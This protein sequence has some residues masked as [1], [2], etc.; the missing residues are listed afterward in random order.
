MH[1][2]KLGRPVKWTSDRTEHFTSDAQGR[3]NV[4]TARMAMDRDGKFL[5]MDLDLIAAMGA[6]LHTFGPY[7]PFLGLTMATGLYDI[8][9]MAA[10][11]RGSYTNTVPGDAYRGAGRPEASYLI[12][13]LVDQCGRELGLS[14]D[15]IRRRNLIR[16][17]Q[18]PYTTPGGRTIDVGE[19]QAH[20][21]GLHEKGKVG[22]V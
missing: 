14:S 13:R 2:K 20:M 8:P 11:M 19:F 1:A 21:E 3:D 22:P 9:V 5:A 10:L 17:E 4:V 6:Y 18:L 12:E 16:P 15:E 7:I